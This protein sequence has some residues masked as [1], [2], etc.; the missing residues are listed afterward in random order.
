MVV[1]GVSRSSSQ[2]TEERERERFLVKRNWKNSHVCLSNSFLIHTTLQKRTPTKRAEE[3]LKE[4]TTL[5]SRKDVKTPLSSPEF[6]YFFVF[7]FFFCEPPEERDDDEEESKSSSRGCCH[8]DQR[9]NDFRF[10]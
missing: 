5:F 8:N 10:F 1:S 2:R 7:F 6:L 4:E 9:E 3:T